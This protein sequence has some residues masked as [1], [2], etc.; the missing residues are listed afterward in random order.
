[1][2]FQ[3][4]KKCV[5]WLIKWALIWAIGLSIISFI[6]GSLWLKFFF[7]TVTNLPS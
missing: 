7:D 4:F 6:I 1:M 5:K 2:N 3:D